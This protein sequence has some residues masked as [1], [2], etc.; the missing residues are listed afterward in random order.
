MNPVHCDCQHRSFCCI[1]AEALEN[2]FKYLSLP[3][4]HAVCFLCRRLN[5]LSV[6]ILLAA[7]G[8]L[9]PTVKCDVHLDGNANSEVD[10]LTALQFAL[11]IP[12]MHHLSITFTRT[13]DTARMARDMERCRPVLHKFPSIRDVSIEFLEIEYDPRFLA[14]GGLNYPSNSDFGD[15]LETIQELPF[16]ESVRIATG[17]DF[18]HNYTLE[19]FPSVVRLHSSLP[20]TTLPSRRTPI[21]FLI[22]TPILVLP[23]FYPWT[24]S[25]LS[26]RNVTALRLHMLIAAVDW[27]IILRD[28]AD[29]VPRL[30]ELTILGIRMPVSALIPLVTEFKALTK[31]TMDSTPD[32]AVE[33]SFRGNPPAGSEMRRNWRS[34]F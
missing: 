6:D 4:I 33:P 24:I 8:I 29:A 11:F 30:A 25:I 13:L 26:C 19:F 28:I 16:L 15:L 20:P 18:N 17:Q 21:T 3:E 9:D 14:G 22:D 31:L 1:S 5:R 34:K 27:A 7:N 23:S 12:S 32:F 10:A 2:L